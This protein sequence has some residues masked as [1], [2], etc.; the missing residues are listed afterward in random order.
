MTDRHDKYSSGLSPEAP[1]GFGRQRSLAD[2]FRGAWKIIMLKAKASAV[3]FPS[4]RKVW[5]P[6][7]N[8]TK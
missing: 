2:F 7:P 4:G 8:P 5:D 6:P 3:R 1:Q